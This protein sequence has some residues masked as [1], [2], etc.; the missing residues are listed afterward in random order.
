LRHPGFATLNDRR[1][2]ANLH[3]GSTSLQPV[4]FPAG[5]RQLGNR[6]RYSFAFATL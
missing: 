6:A 3:L 4:C 5:A 2:K 1:A